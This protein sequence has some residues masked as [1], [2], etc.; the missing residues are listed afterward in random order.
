MTYQIAKIIETCG[1]CP[2]QW[3]AKTDDGK[4]VYIRYRHGQ[5]RVDVDGQ[6][7]MED[8][9]LSAYGGDGVLSYEELVGRT[10]GVLDFSKAQWAETREEV[11]G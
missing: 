6:T 1:A 11:E 4:Y 3:S 7:V 9:F 8:S 10:A 5:F 2:A